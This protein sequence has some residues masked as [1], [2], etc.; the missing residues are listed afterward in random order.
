MRKVAVMGAAAVLVLF[1]ERMSLLLIGEV[2]NLFNTT[3][4]LGVSNTNYSGYANTLARDSEVT[5][6]PGYLH[7]PAFGQPTTTAGGVFGPG[8]PR[9]LP[10]CVTI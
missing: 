2:L 6:D 5:T 4:I 8:G 9:T 10:A 3:N 7:S 1:G